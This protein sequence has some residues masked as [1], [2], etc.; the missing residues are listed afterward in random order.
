MSHYI[1]EGMLYSVSKTI[2]SG[3]V[4]TEI[5]LQG[6]TFCGLIVPASLSSTICTITASPT[7]GGTFTTVKDPT[8]NAAYTI[9]TSGSAAWYFIP[10]IVTASLRYIKINFDQTETSKTITVVYRSMD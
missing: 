6:G 3:T 2:T 1:N 5:D 8:T 10:P 7:T 9:T 4:T